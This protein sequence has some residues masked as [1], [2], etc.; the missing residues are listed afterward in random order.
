VISGNYY[1]SVRPTIDFP[2]L[3]DLALE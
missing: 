3:A 2:T 1:G